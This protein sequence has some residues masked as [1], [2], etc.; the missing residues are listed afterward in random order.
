MSVTDTFPPNVPRRHDSVQHWI[1]IALEFGT[2]DDSVKQRARELPVSRERPSSGPRARVPDAGPLSTS[3]TT[4]AMSQSG[5]RRL[6]LIIDG[7]SELFELRGVEAALGIGAEGRN[8]PVHRREL[9]EL[10]VRL[11]EGGAREATLR[12][13]VANL[14]DAGSLVPLDGWWTA[15]K[16][17][18]LVEESSLPSGAVGGEERS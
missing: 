6:G 13:A 5:G 3:K 11:R 4:P 1:E 7:P 12:R 16:R 15:K 14:V 10:I 9:A 18:D 2:S 17:T 8:G